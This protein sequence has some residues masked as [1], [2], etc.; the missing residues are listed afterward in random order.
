MK[1][2]ERNQNNNKSNIY[3]KIELKHR[4]SRYNS[5]WIILKILNFNKYKKTESHGAVAYGRAK[6]EGFEED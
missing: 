2:T 6:A 3:K 4:R 5:K 1:I